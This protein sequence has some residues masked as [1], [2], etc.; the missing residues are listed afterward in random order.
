MRVTKNM[1]V[2]V[3]GWGHGSAQLRIQNRLCGVEVSYALWSTGTACAQ[4]QAALRS[5][6]PFYKEGNS[7]LENMCACTEA[8]Q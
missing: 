5:A 8:H 3:V 7:S 6:E 4:E 2:T 1:K